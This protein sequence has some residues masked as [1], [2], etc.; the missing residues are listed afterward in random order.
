MTN[1]GSGDLSVSL[2]HTLSF[3]LAWRKERSGGAVGLRDVE[4][5]SPRDHRDVGRVMTFIGLISKFPPGHGA[6]RRKWGRRR[7]LVYPIVRGQ[8]TQSFSV[9]R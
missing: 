3:L 8:Q 1:T 2:T 9:Q 4:S 6:G 7:K 5:G